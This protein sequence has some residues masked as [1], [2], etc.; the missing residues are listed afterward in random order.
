MVRFCRGQQNK[1]HLVVVDAVVLVCRCETRCEKKKESKRLQANSNLFIQGSDDS[2]AAAHPPV[3]SAVISTFTQ[4][5][6]GTG[7]RGGERGEERVGCISQRPV[8]LTVA[9]LH[10]L[11][12][13][14]LL[15]VPGDGAH[16]GHGV[17]LWV[18]VGGVGRVAS[19]IGRCRVVLW[20][21]NSAQ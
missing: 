12:V 18:R 4:S 13:S 5:A 20:M 6:R 14:V 8:V 1:C 7:L 16:V 15:C 9:R 17:A 19:H 21:Q 11:G 3:A 10:A 2:T